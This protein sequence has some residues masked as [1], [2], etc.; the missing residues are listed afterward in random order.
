MGG[1][2][3]ND[4]RL[5]KQVEAAQGHLYDLVSK[6]D[7]RSPP[8]RDFVIHAPR[9]DNS[10]ADAAANLAPD[11]GDF[12]QWDVRGCMQLIDAPVEKTRKLKKSIWSLE[13]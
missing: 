3:L 10:A 11:R 9:R 7:V 5:L 8:G 2:V 6:F 13:A 1:A 4:R 12:G